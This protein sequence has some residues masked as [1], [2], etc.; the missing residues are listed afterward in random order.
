MLYQ[1]M[2]G[3]GKNYNNSGKIYR[4]KHHVKTYPLL[5]RKKEEMYNLKHLRKYNNKIY[6]YIWKA[7]HSAT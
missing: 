4:R 5:F 7:T 2:Q 1:A 6:M 3:K